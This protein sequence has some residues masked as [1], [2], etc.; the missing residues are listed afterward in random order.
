[1]CSKIRIVKI[2]QLKNNQNEY[3]MNIVEKKTLQFDTSHCF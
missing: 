3:K 1:M 2:I